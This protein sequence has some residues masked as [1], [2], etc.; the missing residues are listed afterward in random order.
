VWR[1]GGG[2][3][4]LDTCAFTIRRLHR[5]LVPLVLPL[6]WLQLNPPVSLFFDHAQS[7]LSAP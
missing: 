2:E 7:P 4:E 5:Q 1:R 6:G 3:S